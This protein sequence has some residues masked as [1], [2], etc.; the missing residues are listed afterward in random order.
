M[1]TDL[2]NI[3][4]NN[5]LDGRD[6]EQYMGFVWARDLREGDVVSTG[7]GTYQVS[8]VVETYVGGSKTWLLLHIQI[9]TTLAGP[10]MGGLMRGQFEMLQV[11]AR[12]RGEN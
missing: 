8:R 7:S 11:L 4:V 9:G 12:R 6:Y 1:A 10:I 3:P 5:L 2:L